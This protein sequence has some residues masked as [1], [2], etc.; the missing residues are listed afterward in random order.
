MEKITKAEAQERWETA[1]SKQMELSD[2]LLSTLPALAEGFE[3][4]EENLNALGEE[5]AQNKD[6]I[7]QMETVIFADSH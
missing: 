6:L 7:S 5:S 3:V 4:S 1:V 2:L